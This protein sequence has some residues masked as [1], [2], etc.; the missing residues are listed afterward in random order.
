MSTEPPQVTLDWDVMFCARHRE[1]LRAEWPKH[2]GLAIVGMFNAATADER[3]VSEAGGD[4]KE[5]TSVLGRHRPVC[6]FLGDEIATEVVTLAQRGRVYGQ[7]SPGD[8]GDDVTT[9]DAES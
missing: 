2:A 1:P 4:T 5:L 6:C 9:G 7:A 8:G 3:V